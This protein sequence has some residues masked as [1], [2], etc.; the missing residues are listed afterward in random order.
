L[1]RR[2][3][4]SDDG[5]QFNNGL[6]TMDEASGAGVRN[7]VEVQLLSAAPPKFPGQSQD[8]GA[9]LG[10]AAMVNFFVIFALAMAGLGLWELATGR[11]LFGS[12]RWP[13]NQRATRWGGAYTFTVSLVVAGLAVTYS[14]GI[15][16]MIFGVLVLAFAATVQVITRKRQATV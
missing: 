16:F 10:G 7:D 5:L 3:P 8:A 2:R 4:L 6:V 9:S 13:L 12:R 1:H 14:Y 15:A 11:S